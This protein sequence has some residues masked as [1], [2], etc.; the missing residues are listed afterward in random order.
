MNRKNDL[1]ENTDM[2]QADWTRD[3]PAIVTVNDVPYRVSGHH[4]TPVTQYPR[5]TAPRWRFWW[6]RLF[7]ERQVFVMPTN[8]ILYAYQVGHH[9][10]EWKYIKPNNVSLTDD[11]G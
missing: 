2:K 11:G 10:Y 6:A 5:G 7:G 1:L 8:Y 9:R 4:V 3:E